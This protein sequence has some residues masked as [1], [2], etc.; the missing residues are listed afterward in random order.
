M[1]AKVIVTGG[2]GFI[3]HHLVNKLVK[4]GTTVY[5]VDD[6]SN[7]VIQPDSWQEEGI[8]FR[9]VLPQML[10]YY[11]LES[12]IKNPK[13]INLK[14][15]Y[16]SLAIIKLIAT[17]KIKTVFHLA[18][19]PRVEWSVQNPVIS[20]AENFVK[21]L[22]LLHI[23]AENN[24]RFVFSS[25][26]AVYGDVE[27]L[28]TQED[29]ET[30]PNSPYGLAK[31]CVEKYMSLFENL[32]G[33]DWAA[34][35]YFNVYGPAQPGDSPYSTV[36]S[37]WCCKAMAGQPLRSDGTGEQTRDMVYVDDVVNANIAVSEKSVLP[38]RV[39]NVGSGE[40]QSN[41]Q[42]RQRFIE[43]GY[44]AVQH[45]PERPG[46][47]KDTLANIERLKSIGW[48]AETSFSDGMQQVF[49]YWGL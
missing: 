11:D 30:N 15:D 23:C 25:T 6:Q 1:G 9:E 44:T 8:S 41:N 43:K 33:L 45:Q 38:Y 2:A 19:K 26:A 31:L 16:S 3:G 32:Y 36:V 46:D 42:I 35:R 37:A 28:P 27:S 14:C 13:I 40:R 29:S 10:E 34:L 49:K 4:S 5:L 7:A 21:V 24:T 18:A 22:P 17:G 39:F 20:T 47:V 12:D 48:N